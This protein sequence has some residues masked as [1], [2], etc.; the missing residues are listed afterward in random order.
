[1]NCEPLG[2][3]NDFPLARW[4]RTASLQESPATSGY[5]VLAGNSTAHASA[6]RCWLKAEANGGSEVRHLVSSDSAW[7]EIS[8]AKNCP[9]LLDDVS[10]AVERRAGRWGVVFITD[11]EKAPAAQLG[12]LA[13]RFFHA[14]RCT[15]ATAEIKLAADCRRTLFALSTRFGADALAQPDAR[16]R[17]RHRLLASALSEATPWLSAAAVP[18]ASRQRLRSSIAIVFGEA[19]RDGFA[20]LIAEQEAARAERRARK[21]KQSSP[22]AASSLA[23]RG[24]K[25]HSPDLSVFDRVA[26]QQEVVREVRSRLAGIASGADGGEDAHTF[27]FYGFPGTGKT[28]LAELVALAQHG[29]T[30]APHYQ[31]FSMQN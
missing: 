20:T 16:S 24:G 23:S 17:P 31:R 15:H 8:C 12:A 19:P 26:G 1:M 21:Q 6:L 29:V 28:L 3:S 18:V 27:F 5:V 7:D 2:L 9:S 4:L 25:P 11:A 14:A 10:A 30:A 13:T 22:A